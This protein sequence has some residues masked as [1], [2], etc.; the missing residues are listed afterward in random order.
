MVVNH[1]LS[2]HVIYV[3]EARST[4]RMLV[5]TFWKVVMWKSMKETELRCEADHS[6]PTCAEATNALL[7]SSRHFHGMM[8]Y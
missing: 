1:G 2:E 8:L 3:E 4:Y 5:V 6:P 7:L